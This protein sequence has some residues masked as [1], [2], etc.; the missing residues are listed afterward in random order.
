MHPPTRLLCHCITIQ[1]QQQVCTARV[2]HKR[3]IPPCPGNIQSRTGHQVF[4]AVRLPHEE[5][6]GDGGMVDYFCARVVHSLRVGDVEELDTELNLV[7]ATGGDHDL[8]GGQVSN[9]VL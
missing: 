5:V 4:G 8:E 3:P 6:I 1:R 7:W 9:V 2:I